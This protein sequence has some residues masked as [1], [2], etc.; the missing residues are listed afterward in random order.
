M[1]TLSVQKHRSCFIRKL[2]LQVF[3]TALFKGVDIVTLFKE[4]KN[5]DEDDNIFSPFILTHANKKIHKQFF[6]AKNKKE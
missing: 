4:I 1:R 3:Q 5:T 6:D 2:Q